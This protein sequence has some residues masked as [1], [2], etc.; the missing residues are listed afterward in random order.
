MNISD[1]LI[2]I[3]QHLNAQQRQCLEDAMREIDGVIAPRFNA[4]TD[5]LLLIAFNPAAT[6]AGVLLNQVRACGYDAQ[7]IGT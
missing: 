3:N 2:H 7:L 1:V 6:A 4:G 5:H